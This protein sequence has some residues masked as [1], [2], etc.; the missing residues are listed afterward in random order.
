MKRA[1]IK[2]KLYPI[3]FKGKKYY[4]KDC[5]DLFAGVYNDRESYELGGGG[6]YIS[7]GFTIFPD[8]TYEDTEND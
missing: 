6:V 5:D 4:E 3:F 2:E 8:G 1:T 7:N